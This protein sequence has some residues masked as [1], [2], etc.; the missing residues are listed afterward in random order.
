[1]DTF[2][3]S[4]TTDI[5]LIFHHFTL[6]FSRQNAE[7]KLEGYNYD[8]KCF[9]IKNWIYIKNRRLKLIIKKINLL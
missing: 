2:R 6:F 7:R 1:M 8:K 3:S 9:K 5:D 4:G